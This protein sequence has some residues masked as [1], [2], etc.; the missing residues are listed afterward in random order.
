VK[1]QHRKKKE[2]NQSLNLLPNGAVQ[3]G[4]AANQIAAQ[5][6]GKIGEEQL[7]KVHTARITDPRKRSGVNLSPEAHVFLTG[8]WVSPLAGAC[9]FCLSCVFF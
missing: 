5:N 3:R 9:I 4:E 6:Q 2:I 7:G 1:Q 8:L